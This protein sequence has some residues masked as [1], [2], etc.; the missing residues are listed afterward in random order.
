VTFSVDGWASESTPVGLTA[1]APTAM[2]AL[3]APRSGSCWYIAARQMMPAAKR[4][5][6]IGMKTTV[7]KAT[8]QLTRSVITAKMSP[9]AVTTAG[10]TPIQMALFLIAVTVLA[11]LKS[12]V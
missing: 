10:T 5:M 8:D 4:E 6:A 9:I 1:S 2:M 3:I 11:S 7:L 12:R